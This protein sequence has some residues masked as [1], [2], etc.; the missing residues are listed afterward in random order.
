M[1]RFTGDPT[2]DTSSPF[3]KG[4]YYMTC[5]DATECKTKKTPSRDMFTLELV[6]TDGHPH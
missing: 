5:I 2:K 4:T 6:V 1:V 3:P